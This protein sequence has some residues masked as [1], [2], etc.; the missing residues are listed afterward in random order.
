MKIKE[1]Y[2]RRF[3]KLKDYRLT[4]NDGMNVLF[5]NNEAGKTT[6]F[7]FIL[8][9]LYGFSNTRSKG[10]AD[11]ARKKYMTW[12]EN[13][14]GGTMTVENNG[15]TYV[16][17]RSFGKTKAGDSLEFTNLTLGEQIFLPNG[18]EVGEYLLDLDEKTFKG[19]CFIGQLNKN[20]VCDNDSVKTKLS[21]LSSSGDAEYSFDDVFGRLKSASL[22][23]TRNT[24][25]G[26]KYPLEIKKNE[27]EARNRII[28]TELH[29]I[30]LIDDENKELEGKLATL[31]SEDSEL[32]RNIATAKKYLKAQKYKKAVTNNERIEALRIEYENCVK[33]ITHNGFVADKNYINRLNA[34]LKKRDDIRIKCEYEEKTLENERKTLEM[35]ANNNK[36]DKKG[37]ASLWL[38]LSGI[39]IAIVA[40]LLYFALKSLVVSGVAL[41][42]G[43]VF[44]VCACVFGNKNEAEAH[45]E[46]DVAFA[47]ITRND[48]IS[49]RLEH[50][51]EEYRLCDDEF[52]SQY[53]LFFENDELVINADDNI[54]SLSAM[55][56]RRLE[57]KIRY[58]AV[59]GSVI[60]HQ[61][62]EQMRLDVDDSELN[63]EFGN[64]DITELE[65]KR[66]VISNELL[67]AEK[68]LLVNKERVK[69]KW[70]LESELKNNLSEIAE[71]NEKIIAY[72]YARDCL[73]LAKQGVEKAQTEM[74][75]QFAPDVSRR[76]SEIL[77]EITCGKYEQMTLSSNLN[78]MIV[79]NESG[80]AYDDGYM[81]AGTLDQIYLSLRLAMIDLIYAD[82]EYPAICMDD[83]LLSFDFNRMKKAIEYISSVS[84]NKAQVIFFT[85][86]DTERDCFESAN[87][88]KV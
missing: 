26:K 45:T 38:F 13:K 11:S 66:K 2:I 8:A 14:M 83:A 55:I 42:V 82:K 17:D 63:M 46:R 54:I 60:P 70:N 4:L 58:D 69:S 41:A 50:L 15:T 18:R 10:I 33:A 19:T 7:N 44:V 20:D 43:I 36:Q 28:D 84:A 52:K 79:D 31:S 67:S 74:Q 21:N 35:L 5:G 53:L 30:T 62:I 40:V 37:T 49:E 3:G 34:L 88:I 32:E 59:S 77:S 48:A 73:E 25:T 23:I 80:A 16:I 24:V 56:D 51:K 39:V 47:Q 86:R 57:A 78:T 71:I 64:I 76:V 87:L 27:L 29:R 72:D 65:A 1:L 6:I 12:G 22:E 9:M 85:C 68:T 81:S 75:K 61:T